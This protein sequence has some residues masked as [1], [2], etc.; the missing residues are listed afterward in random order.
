MM[1]SR[2]MYI[3]CMLCGPVAM[4]N[5]LGEQDGRAL[6]GRDQFSSRNCKTWNVINEI[7]GEYGTTIIKPI[8]IV[9]LSRI[10]EVRLVAGKFK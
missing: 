4:L 8:K 1:A 10:Q 6:K 5:G 9:K 2:A 7:V 3:S